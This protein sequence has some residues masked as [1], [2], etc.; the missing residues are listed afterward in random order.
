MLTVDANSS[1]LIV[2][3]MQARLT[4][5]IDGVASV[6]A[7]VRRLVDAAALFAIPALFTEQNPKGLGATVARLSPDPSIVVHKM[8][9]DACRSPEF[10]LRVPAG[11]AIVL[12]GCEAHVCVLQS[13]LGLVDRGRRVFVVS[14]AIGS[15]R[16]ESKQTAIARMARHGVEIVTTEMV[17]FEWL[18]TA[19]H[20]RFKEAAALIK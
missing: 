15:R 2:I 9:F 3:D 4:P 19:E 7:N 12:A 1:M 14:D 18:G 17:I 8:T 11:R 5:A 6:L 16:A 13:A 20:P 10:L